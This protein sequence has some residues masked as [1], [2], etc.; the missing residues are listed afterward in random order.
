MR[1]DSSQAGWLAGWLVIPDA[2]ETQG[3][4]VATNPAQGRRGHTLNGRPVR[5]V[6]RLIT[7]PR[8]DS[9]SRFF[10]ISRPLSTNALMSDY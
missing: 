6:F 9:L 4:I 7:V 3:T 1:P 5:P 2:V 10:Q 8:D